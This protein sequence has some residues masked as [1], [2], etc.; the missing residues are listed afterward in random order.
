[1]LA[2]PEVEVSVSSPEYAWIRIHGKAVFED[3]KEC[4]RKDAWIIQSLR[5]KNSDTAD[6]PIFWGILSWK[7]SWCNRRFSLEIH[8]MNF[9]NR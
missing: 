5:D 3:N 7:S 6:N 1:M 2:N 8:L 9:N 4:A